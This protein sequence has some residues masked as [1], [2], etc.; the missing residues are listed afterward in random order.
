MLSALKRAL[1]KLILVQGELALTEPDSTKVCRDCHTALPLNQFHKNAQCVDG[2]RPE[3]RQCVKKYRRAYYLERQE[4]LRDYS[5]DYY[6]NN[7]EQ[8]AEAAKKYAAE[9]KHKIRPRF[10]RWYAA[11]KESLLEKKRQDYRKNKEHYS[12]IARASREKN[13]AQNAAYRKAYEAANP[14]I[15]RFNRMRHEMRKRNAA[16]SCTSNLWRQKCEYHGW[17]CIYCRA[18]LTR[19]TVTI[20]H[21]KPLSKGGSNWPANL[22]PCCRQCN[23]SKN[24]KSETEFRAYL[25]TL[26]HFPEVAKLIC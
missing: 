4:N 22:G 13:K 10:L 1:P 5:N 7:R 19:K 9:N 3:C 25:A 11:N 21:R 24:K 12:R 18:L 17:R 16:G 23:Q 2:R 8:V 6:K 26:N 14:D 20:E 15:I